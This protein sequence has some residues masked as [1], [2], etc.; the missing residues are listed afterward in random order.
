M[1]EQYSFNDCKQSVTTF[2]NGKRVSN[3]YMLEDEL[4]L[5]SSPQL[6]EGET[7]KNDS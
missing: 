2:R 5:D 3:P 6:Q 1:E 4:D 7:L